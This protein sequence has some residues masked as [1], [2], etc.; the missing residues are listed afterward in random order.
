VRLLTASFM[1]IVHKCSGIALP[2]LKAER[3]R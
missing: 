2:T 1:T 3:I